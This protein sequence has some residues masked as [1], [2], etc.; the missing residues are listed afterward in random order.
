[1]NDTKKQFTAKEISEDEHKAN[2]KNIDELTK[3]WTAKIDTLVKLK[4]E[5]LMKI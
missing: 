3:N 1:M 2:E 4:T 5:E